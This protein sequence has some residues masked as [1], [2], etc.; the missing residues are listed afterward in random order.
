MPGQVMAS[1]LV[2][3]NGRTDIMTGTPHEFPDAGGNIVTVA[4]GTE[5]AAL[6]G[7]LTVSSGTRTIMEAGTLTILAA[8]IMPIMRDQLMSRGVAMQGERIRVFLENTT[9]APVQMS[10]LVDLS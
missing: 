7:T 3:A 4:A 5:G 10:A 2:P 8:G 6:S 1:V 9:G